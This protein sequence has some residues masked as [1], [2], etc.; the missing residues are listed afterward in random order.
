MSAVRKTGKPRALENDPE[1]NDIDDEIRSTLD[2]D[3][4]GQFL[5][6]THQIS[7][8]EIKRAEVIDTSDDK[9]TDPDDPKLPSWGF[10]REHFKTK[11]AIIRHLHS[12]GHKPAVISR[13]TG[14]KYQHVRNVL[15]IELKRGPNES[16]KLDDYQAP[17]L[18][19]T[20]IK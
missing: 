19:P 13:H 2:P 17:N 9:P 4:L 20:E 6:D 16:F 3:D 12:L 18:L 10:L 7:K 11:S 15:T 1:L 8:E 5:R 14:F